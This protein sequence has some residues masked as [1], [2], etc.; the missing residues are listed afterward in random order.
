MKLKK[1]I[2]IYFAV[3]ASILIA[4]ALV[5]FDYKHSGGKFVAPDSS[6]IAKQTTPAKRTELVSYTAKDGK[7]IK[8]LVSMEKSEDGWKLTNMRVGR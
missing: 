8:L 6:G 1:N 5:Y 3:A 4:V 2:L 7:K